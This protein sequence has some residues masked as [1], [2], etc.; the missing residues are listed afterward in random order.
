M[1]TV[2]YN[3]DIEDNGVEKHFLS[4]TE[5]AVSLRKIL[6]NWTVLTL[7]TSICQN[8]P[9]KKIVSHRMELTSNNYN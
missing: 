9:L 4:R 8:T 3:T 2:V 6:I 1:T 5:K 7:I